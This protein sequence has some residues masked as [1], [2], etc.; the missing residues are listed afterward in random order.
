M[1]EIFRQY[2]FG[3]VL[4]IIVIVAFYLWDSPRRTADAKTA[5]V[6]AGPVRGNEDTRIFHVPGCP[7]YT[8]IKPGNVREFAS[9]RDAQEANFKGSMNCLA[10]IRHRLAYENGEGEDGDG[11]Y[12]DPRN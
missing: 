2:G 8:S 4:A 9:V 10:E 1:K 7:Q 11:S 6:M 5:A 3:I 12:E